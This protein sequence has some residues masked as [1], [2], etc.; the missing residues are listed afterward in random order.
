MIGVPRNECRID[1]L[2]PGKEQNAR[3]VHQSARQRPT[4]GKTDDSDGG[5]DG[6]DGDG[7]DDVDDDADVDDGSD[8]DDDDDGGGGDE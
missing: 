2:R 6:D 8:D 5:V 3:G 1:P 7:G 4:R